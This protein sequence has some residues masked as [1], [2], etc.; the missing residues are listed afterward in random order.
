[1]FFPQRE[2]PSFTPNKANGKIL[3]LYILIFIFTD[4]KRDG[5]RFWTEW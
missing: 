3:V 4:S 5:K 2:R 1:V